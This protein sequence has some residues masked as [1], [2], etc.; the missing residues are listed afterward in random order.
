MPSPTPL[1]VASIDWA[2]WTP[3]MRATLL[4]V[5]HEGQALLIRS[6]RGLGQGKINA[7]GGKIDPGE[8]P[9]QGAIRELEEEVGVR[10]IGPVVER[11]ELS[12]EFVDGLRLHVWVFTTQGYAGDVIETDEAVPL[13]FPLDALP[14]DEMWPDDRFWVPQMLAGERIAL[15][16]VFDGHTMCDH[17]LD[18]TASP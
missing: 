16:A 12:F 13:W 14:Y 1:T 6:K 18:T 11:G 15:R 2:S 8:T 17:T 3:T 10:P 5:F 7:P 9:R 4:F